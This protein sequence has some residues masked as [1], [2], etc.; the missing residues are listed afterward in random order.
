MLMRI[1]GQKRAAIVEPIAELN[2]IKIQDNG[3]P[4]VDVLDI[5]YGI[6]VM[7]ED[8]HSEGLGEIQILCSTARG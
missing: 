2:K 8:E 3:E 7:P 5:C 1:P 6:E 4:L